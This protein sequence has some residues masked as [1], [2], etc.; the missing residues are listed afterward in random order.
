MMNRS[1]L[2]SWLYDKALLQLLETPGT[3]KRGKWFSQQIVYTL[4]QIHFTENS[5]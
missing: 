3:M 2:D 4:L 5:Q 1:L